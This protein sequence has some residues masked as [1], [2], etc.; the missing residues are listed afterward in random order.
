MDPTFVT[1]ATTSRE[2]GE[3]RDQSGEAVDCAVPD[4]ARGLVALVARTKQ[5]SAEVAR[6]L[7]RRP[8]RRSR[9]ARAH[10]GA[11]HDAVAPRMSGRAGGG[12]SRTP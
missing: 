4:P 2:A 11:G 9:A 6:Y 5:L 7:A 12:A 8:P 1:A 3:A 10:G